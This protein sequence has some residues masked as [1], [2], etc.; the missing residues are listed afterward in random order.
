MSSYD[1]FRYQQLIDAINSI[2]SYSTKPFEQLLQQQK[3]IADAFCTI[4]RWE[5]QNVFKN[6][7]VKFLEI[8]S[9]QALTAAMKTIKFPIPD[10]KST[11]LF[12]FSKLIPSEVWLTEVKNGVL[13]NLSLRDTLSLKSDISEYLRNNKLFPSEEFLYPLSDGYPNGYRYSGQNEVFS[14]RK[15]HH[16]LKPNHR[17]KI[18]SSSSIKLKKYTFMYLLYVLL[19]VLCFYTEENPAAVILLHPIFN[20]LADYFIDEQNRRQNDKQ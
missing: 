17:Y 16:S 5:K 18:S 19:A 14:D 15:I 9:T 10:L 12:E 3:S 4:T 11:T 13:D 6:L 20:T 1:T 7:H 8:S 2:R